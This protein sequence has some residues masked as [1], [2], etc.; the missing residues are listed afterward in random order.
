M[1]LKNSAGYLVSVGSLVRDTAGV[2]Y[3]VED[4]TATQVYVVTT[5]PP[6]R[7]RRCKPA[8]LGLVV[9]SHTADRTKFDLARKKLRSYWE[10]E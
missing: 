8:E 4:I 7:Q 10:S 1:E 9:A 2:E 5:N 6:R 3:R